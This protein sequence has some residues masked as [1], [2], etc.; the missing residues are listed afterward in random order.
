MDIQTIQKNWKDRGFSCEVWTDPPGQVW[1]DF[2]HETDELVF[3][4]E[5]E[6]ELEMKGKKQLLKKEE[7]VLIPAKV[8][9]SVRNKG[10]GPSKWLYGYKKP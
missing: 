5:G 6:L 2:R 4:L 7:E 3:L 10:R 8:L 9:H 1:E